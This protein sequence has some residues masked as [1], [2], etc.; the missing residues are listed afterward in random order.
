[1]PGLNLVFPP[2]TV[3]YEDRPYHPGWFLYAW[4]PR[5]LAGWDGRGA[6]H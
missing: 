6:G 1:M 2:M 4:P 3:D 5:R